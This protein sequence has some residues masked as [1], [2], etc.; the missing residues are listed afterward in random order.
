MRFAESL[1]P[2]AYLCVLNSGVFEDFLEGSCPRVQ[3]GQFDLSTRFVNR[4]YL[5]D[6]SNDLQVAGNVVEELAHFGRRIHAGDMPELGQIDEMVARAY[7]L[8]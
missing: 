1:L 3:G 6:L 4:L 5:P 8:P 7:G 2:W